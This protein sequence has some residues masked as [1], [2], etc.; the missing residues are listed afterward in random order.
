M[1]AGVAAGHAFPARHA[2]FDDEAEG[3]R[4]DAQVDALDAQ[5]RHADHHPG[6]GGQAARG[7][8]GQRERPARADAHRLRVGTHAQERGVADG[9]LPRE[10]GQ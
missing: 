3:Q 10:A 7:Q 9:K 8:H 2:F 6:R 5:R 4:G 1:H